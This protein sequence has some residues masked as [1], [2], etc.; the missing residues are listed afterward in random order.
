M[1]AKDNA[2]LPDTPDPIP[3]SRLILGSAMLIAGFLSPLAIPW[4]AG[5]GL[6]AGWKATISGLLIFGIPELMMLLAGA[7]M[8]KAGFTYLREQAARFLQRYGPP[9]TVGP[10]RYRLG[11]V[12]FT[13]PLLVGL[14]TPYLSHHIPALEANHLSIAL[15]GDLML[16]ISLFVLGGDFWDKLRALF[17]R[18]ARIQWP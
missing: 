12:L 5:S 2:V 18:E 4:I 3:R 1:Q 14:L 11:L 9:D 10:G 8:G 15:A 17:V 13:L 6:P 7:V 16:L